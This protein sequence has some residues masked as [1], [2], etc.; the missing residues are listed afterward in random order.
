MI[1]TARAGPVAV[2]TRLFGLVR[3]GAAHHDRVADEAA[4]LVLAAPR[5]SAIT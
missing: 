1:G 5:A 4:D 3:D 2:G